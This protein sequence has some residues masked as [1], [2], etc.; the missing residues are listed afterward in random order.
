MWCALIL[1]IGLPL[2]LALAHDGVIRVPLP[3]LTVFPFKGL[4]TVNMLVVLWLLTAFG[5]LVFWLCSLLP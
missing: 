4:S 3:D 5:G 1:A 2:L